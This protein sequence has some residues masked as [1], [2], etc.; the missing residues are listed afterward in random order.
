M[1]TG[2]ALIESEIPGGLSEAFDLKP[3]VHDRGGEREVRFLYRHVPRLLPVWHEGRLI[4]ARWGNQRHQSRELP[5]T[6]WTWR[7]TVDSGG[8]QPWQPEPVDIP[9]NF[10]LENGVWYRVRQGIRGLLARD[11]E[12]LPVAY[13]ICEPATRYYRV[14]TR[15]DRMPTLIGEVI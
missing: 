13:M 10:A 5:L 6:G 11:E 14:M 4:I 8:W 3:R 1:C 7:Q 9:A 2:V 12:G 15:S